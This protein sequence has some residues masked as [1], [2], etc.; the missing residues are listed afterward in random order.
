MEQTEIKVVTLQLV[1]QALQ[2]LPLQAV[3]LEAV[4][5]T[6][7]MVTL[8]R[9]VQVVLVA[10]ALI[11]LT[12]IVKQLADKVQEQLIKEIMVAAV[13]PMVIREQVAEVVLLPQAELVVMVVVAAAVPV[14]HQQSQVLQ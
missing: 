5:D 7:T 3:V 2:Q 11:K 1:V 4:E 6:L 12:E 8:A 14:E 10:E 13:H 9:A